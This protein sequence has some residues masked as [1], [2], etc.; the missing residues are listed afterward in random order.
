M[1]ESQIFEAD[2]T[3]TG[4]GFE[5]SVQISTNKGVI[6]SVGRLG[7]EPT[8]RL[9]RKALLPGMVNAHSHAFQRGLRGL[10]ERFPEGAGDFW[11]W[12]EA[13]YDLVA[14]LDARSFS[15]TCK[16][17]FSEMLAA[18]IT[19]VGEFHY[20]HHS[21]SGLDYAFDEILLAAAREAGIRLVLLTAFYR[22]GAIGKELNPAQQRFASKS[23]A[24]YW[25]QI[26]RLSSLIDPHNQSLGAVAHSIRAADLDEIIS[27][28]GEASGRGLVFHMHLEE[29]RREIEESLDAYG[30]PPMAV[31]N[32]SLAIG[33][34][35]TA[36]HCTHTAPGDME[37]FLTSG[38]NV[39]LC[40]ITEANLGDGIPAAAH[41][42]GVSGNICIGSDS[43]SRIS[44]TEELRWLEY[45]QRLVSERRGIL[46]DGDGSV[47]RKL[48]EIATANGARSLGVKTGAIESGRHA[49]L[50]AIDLNSPELYGWTP[51][52]LLD[53][54]IF[55]TGNS[56]ITDVCVGGR[57]REV[58][59]DE[60]TR[61]R[62]NEG[63]VV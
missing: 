52:T 9:S 25:E 8:K 58:R 35:F 10:G 23:T 48:F 55:G 37:T 53:A 15:T 16:Q 60:G 18:G 30:R 51:E 6:D 61:E 33:E 42:H 2:L 11:S 1:S 26:D 63:R 22:T 50:I 4:S 29:Q 19:T 46:T 32:D 17:A 47:A 41:I 3:W 28:Y 20:I 13:M 43:N 38:G 49:D 14:T 31:L 7:A 24:D 39:C 21:Q 40:P 59:G 34:N 57:W 27:L 5:P 54:F 36:V 44:F 62:S 56:V 45:V 12:R